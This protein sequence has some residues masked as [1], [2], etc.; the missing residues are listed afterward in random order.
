MLAFVLENELL[1][2]GN[3]IY[4]NCVY[5]IQQVNGSKNKNNDDIKIIQ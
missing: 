3:P 5:F 2:S 1:N 4:H